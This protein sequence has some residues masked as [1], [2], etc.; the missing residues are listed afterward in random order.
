MDWK[1]V[2]QL[3]VPFAPTLGKVLGGFIPFPG[4][5]ILGE[6]AGKALADALGVPATPDAVGAAIQNSSPEDVQARLEAAENEAKARYDMMARVAEAEAAD[7]TAQSQTINETI[8]AETAANVGTV[9]KWHWRNTIGH[10]VVLY[11]LQQIML[12]F[13][14]AFFP[15][16]LA[17]SDFVLLV[18]ATV[19]F[20][21]GLFALLGY[22][23][24]DT[25]DRYKTAITGD[26]GSGGIVEKVIKAVKPAPKSKPPGARD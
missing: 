23:A 5:A 19:V 13:V 18:N 6:W 16:V 15:K 26:R 7:R 22:V 25:T 20:T 17:P 21:G 2:A 10:L 24:S 14:A 9:S 12:L 8:R 4:G 1:A 3:V 11:G